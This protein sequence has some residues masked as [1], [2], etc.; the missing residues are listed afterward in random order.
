MSEKRKDIPEDDLDDLLDQAFEMQDLIH[1]KC[2]MRD[3]PEKKKVEW[4]KKYGK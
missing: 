3:D 2:Q 4:E 1:H